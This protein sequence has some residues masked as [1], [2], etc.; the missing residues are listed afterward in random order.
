MSI[1]TTFSFCAYIDFASMRVALPYKI[2]SWSAQEFSTDLV[3]KIPS[4]QTRSPSFYEAFASD[5]FSYDKYHK[6]KPSG[7]KNKVTNNGSSTFRAWSL[8]QTCLST[9]NRDRP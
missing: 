7:R 4:V 6:A 3:E 5:S 2:N 1:G 8:G 9:D